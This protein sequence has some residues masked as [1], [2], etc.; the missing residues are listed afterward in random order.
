MFEKNLLL[1]GITITS[2]VKSNPRSEFQD[3]LN[4]IHFY[5]AD[6]KKLSIKY[7]SGLFSI[8]ANYFG[9]YFLSQAGIGY[10]RYILEY[11]TRLVENRLTF[12]NDTL[13]QTAHDLGF[14]DVSHLNK[15]YKQLR[16]IYPSNVRKSS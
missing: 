16:G 11:R 12:S 9:E 13:S 2:E 15:I 3:I 10:K 6:P 1:N 5:I 4:H 14:S 8:S 7:I